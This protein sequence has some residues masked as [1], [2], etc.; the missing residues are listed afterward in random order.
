MKLI[1]LNSQQHGFVLINVDK[2][3][4]IYEADGLTRMHIGEYILDIEESIDKIKKMMYSEPIQDGMKKYIE[5]NA[6]VKKSIDDLTK[7]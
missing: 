6:K 4:I 3:N 1:E 2:I 5:K 7:L